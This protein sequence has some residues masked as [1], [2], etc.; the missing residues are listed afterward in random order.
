MDYSSYRPKQLKIR[1]YSFSE[2]SLSLNPQKM[3]TLSEKNVAANHDFCLNSG[4]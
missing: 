1:I 3:L 4:S 2:A